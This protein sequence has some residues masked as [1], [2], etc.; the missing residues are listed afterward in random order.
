[1]LAWSPLHG[2][3]LGGALRKLADGT[4]VKTAQGRAME[5]L[6]NHRDTIAKYEKF[7]ADIGLDPAEV[8]IAWVLSRPALTAAVIGPRTLFHLESA[9]RAL[10]LRL[11]DDVLS[12]LD[13]MFPQPA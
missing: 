10:E 13:A 11:P 9:L 8:G 12:E 3:L 1:V 5:A 7:C 2:G 6:P 4:A